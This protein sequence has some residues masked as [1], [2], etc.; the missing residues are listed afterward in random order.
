MIVCCRVS[1]L[2]HPA[3][4]TLLRPVQ[5]WWKFIAHRGYRGRIIKVT[6][7]EVRVELEAQQRSVGVPRDA[8]PP[9]HG[10]APLPRE[11]PRFGAAPST[12]AHLGMAT[13]SHPWVRPFIFYKIGSPSPEWLYLTPKTKSYRVKSHLGMATPSHACGCPF[14]FYTTGSS[15]Y[16]K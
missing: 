6:P 9:E 11:P 7:T 5:L 14:I 16:E 8:I 3:L 13:P 2:L 12:P 1:S 10:G 4:Q 15:K